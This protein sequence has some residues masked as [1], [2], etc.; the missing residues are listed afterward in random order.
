MLPLVAS[1]W[2]ADI[3]RPST[4]MSARWCEVSFGCIVAD[5]QTCSCPETIRWIW[6]KNPYSCPWSEIMDSFLQVKGSV[7]MS[8]IRDSLE[9]AMMS[10]RCCTLWSDCCTADSLTS[11][12]ATRFSS[13]VDTMMR[14]QTR[15]VSKLLGNRMQSSGSSY[16]LFLSFSHLLSHTCMIQNVCSN[17]I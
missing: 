9:W 4:L 2:G 7:C 15:Y 17:G 13:S 5:F 3:L 10:T 1:K 11:S 8:V 16:C 12:R 6:R 14:D